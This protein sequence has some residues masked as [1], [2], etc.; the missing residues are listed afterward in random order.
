MISP[1]PIP[2]CHTAIFLL[3][4]FQISCLCPFPRTVTRCQV[5]VDCVLLLQAGHAVCYLVRNVQ[6]ADGLNVPL[7]LWETKVS[8]R[9][10]G[11]GLGLELGLGLGLG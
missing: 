9:V 8:V 6:L 7:G 2:L 4:F 11:L 3:F 10:T 5:A 1:L